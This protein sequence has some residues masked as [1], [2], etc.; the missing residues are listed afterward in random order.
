MAYGSS[1]LSYYIPSA[2]HWQG[3]KS[4]T[5]W[6]YLLSSSMIVQYDLMASS[7]I[8]NLPSSRIVTLL[9]RKLP[10]IEGAV[11]LSQ[12]PVWLLLGLATFLIRIPALICA[13]DFFCTRGGSLLMTEEQ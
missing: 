1:F 11:A 4:P 9:D 3:E 2:M 8:S 6:S 10:T 7:T 13:A 5:S 12:L